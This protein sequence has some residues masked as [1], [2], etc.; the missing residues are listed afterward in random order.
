MIDLQQLRDHARAKATHSFPLQNGKECLAGDLTGGWCGY[1]SVI[2]PGNPIPQAL[3]REWGRF[4]IH[5]NQVVGY[6]NPESHFTGAQVA[7]ALDRMIE[8][9]GPEDTADWLK[10]QVYG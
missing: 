1:N 6:V 4:L 7:N 10:E 5:L 9:H 3:P 2:L 8:G